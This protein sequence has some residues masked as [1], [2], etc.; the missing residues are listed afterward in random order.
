MFASALKPNSCRP[1]RGR[2]CGRY[3]LSGLLTNFHSDCS[4]VWFVL[5]GHR[6]RFGK[7]FN[8]FR[9]ATQNDG[10]PYWAA[11]PRTGN[12]RADALGLA[13]LRAFEV[14]KKLNPGVRLEKYCNKFP[15][16]LSVGFKSVV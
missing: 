15:R 6:V 11:R 3:F 13:R 14:M 2:K 8:S 4:E 7:S 1:N 10:P 5:A 9:Q 16:H 12:P